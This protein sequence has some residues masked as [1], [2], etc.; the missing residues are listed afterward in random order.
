[1]YAG[2]FLTIDLR[3]RN[4]GRK[5]RVLPR[6][7]QLDVVTDVPLMSIFSGLRQ[8]RRAHRRSRACHQP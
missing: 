2:H 8:V 5:E 6:D 3:T 1:M 7:Y 4:R